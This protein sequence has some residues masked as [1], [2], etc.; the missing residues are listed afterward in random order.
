M[1]SY[2]HFASRRSLMP[3]EPT[4]PFWMSPGTSQRFT[5]ILFFPFSL[6]VVLSDV[7]IFACPRNLPLFSSFIYLSLS[8]FSAGG[9]VTFLLIAKFCPC[10][11]I[12]YCHCR[13]GYP[14]DIDK[15]WPCTNFISFYFILF[16]IVNPQILHIMFA[17]YLSW[18]LSP[19]VLV[20]LCKQ[21]SLS[22]SKIQPDAKKIHIIF[23]INFSIQSNQI[24]CLE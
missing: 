22:K 14:E 21:N 2:F 7:D 23:A 18:S 19:S 13:I 16:A 1:F 9:F 8:A 6:F 20:S 12:L 11:R 10:Y 24:A 4:Q 3:I 5:A 17:Y 15:L